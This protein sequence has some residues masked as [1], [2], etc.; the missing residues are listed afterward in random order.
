MA[1]RLGSGL[2]PGA[3]LNYKSIFFLS[4]KLTIAD[5][6]ELGWLVSL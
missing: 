4:Q 1:Q 6:S 3:I 2:S 5:L